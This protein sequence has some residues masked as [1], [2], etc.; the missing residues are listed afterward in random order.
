MAYLDFLTAHS[1]RLLSGTLITIAQFVL[2]ALVAVA[3]ALV[4]GL[5]KLAPVKPVRGVATVY[6][7]IFRGTSLL[8]QLYWIFFALPLFGINLDKFS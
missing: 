4:S 1:D 7:E 5:M 2:A 6:I 8:V 3:A